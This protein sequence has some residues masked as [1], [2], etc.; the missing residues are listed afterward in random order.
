VVLSELFLSLNCFLIE[1]S[2]LWFIALGNVEVVWGELK[3]LWQGTSIEQDKCE[4]CVRRAVAA[5]AIDVKV[6][7]SCADE[8]RR[9]GIF[10]EEL[11]HKRGNGTGAAG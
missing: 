4:R 7:T 11:E 2:C 8:A 10:I 9:L 5:I 3:V 1:A 6:C